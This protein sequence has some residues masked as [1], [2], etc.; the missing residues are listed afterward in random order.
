MSK[1]RTQIRLQQITGSL[2][3]MKPTSISKG[4]AITSLSEGNIPSAQEIFKY[5]A[6]AL[7]NMSGD[8]AFGAVEPGEYKSPAS[9]DGLV[10]LRPTSDDAMALGRLTVGSINSVSSFIIDSTV[11][12]ASTSLSKDSGWSSPSSL[13]KGTLIVLRDS[14]N[15]DIVFELTSAFSSSDSSLL[16]KF[17]PGYSHVKSM[18]V[19]AASQKGY[20]SAGSLATSGHASWSSINTNRV[21]GGASTGLDVA[22]A[23]GILL[24]QSSGSVGGSPLD[25]SGGV[26][27]DAVNAV[28]IKGGASSGAAIILDTK[29][30]STETQIKSAGTPLL[31]VGGSAGNITMPV[32]SQTLAF[33]ADAATT[34]THADGVG[35]VLAGGEDKLAFVQADGAESISSSA[36]G[37]LD[38][39]AGTLLKPVAPTIELEASTEVLLDTPKVHLEDDSS[40]LAF[41]DGEDVTFTHDGSTGMDVAA[42]GAFDVTAGAQSVIKT[43]AAGLMLS[44]ATNVGIAAAAGPVFLDGSQSVGIQ[45]DGTFAFSAIAAL[46][47]TNAEALLFETPSSSEASTYI[48]N[49]STSTSVLGAINSLFSSVTSGE[50]TLFSGSIAS[51]TS[52]GAAVTLTKLAGDVSSF[53]T[54]IAPN[55]LDVYVNGQLMKSGSET[56][57]AAGNVDYAVSGTNELKF[58]FALVYE[59]LVS[60]IDR[61]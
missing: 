31:K 52:A 27:I 5:Y 50:P 10:A 34:L 38:L 19:S 53:G 57:R 44:G 33:G 39:A 32:D 41:G 58:S 8:V 55:K 9:S 35:L 30:G 24:L 11:S 37:I 14:S 40:V 12:Y 26:I 23:H 17:V 59:D 16:V 47:G 42:A 46:A 36:D 2:T 25:G 60:A 54:S 21:E 7:S 22:A 18:S 61:S 13:E 29:F 28:A 3:D 51:T 15:N 4:T 56:D 48:S 43:S 49:F 6:Q 45:T 1:S 20:V